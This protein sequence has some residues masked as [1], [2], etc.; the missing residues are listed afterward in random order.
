MITPLQPKEFF[1]GTWRGQGELVPHLLI[2]WLLPRE[3][4]RFSTEAIW[5]S[6]TVWVV[7]DRY[8][9][10]SGR[11]MQ[12]KMFAELVTPTRI[13]LTADDMP[14]GAD[15]LLHEKGFDFAPYYILAPFGGRL[16]RLHC[17][18]VC[19]LDEQGRVHDNLRMYWCGCP[20][21]R[22][23]VGPIERQS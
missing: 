21:A 20:V 1:R 7:N 22:I 16:F 4:I 12:K 3:R 17:F 11:V 2:R 6:D 8:E 18:D 10:S 5:L 15:I 9:F 13:H 23:Y 14:F 19:R